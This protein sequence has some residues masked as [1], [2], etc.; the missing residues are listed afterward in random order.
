[1]SDEGKL[2][3][4]GKERGRKKSLISIV[5]RMEKQMQGYD[6][7]IVMIT[8]G[9][10]IEDAELILYTITS[11]ETSKNRYLRVLP[12]ILKTIFSLL[13]IWTRPA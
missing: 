8:H 12:F 9:D 11:A 5:D 1:M 10:G 2:V 3:V 4:I 6:N 7:D 13:S